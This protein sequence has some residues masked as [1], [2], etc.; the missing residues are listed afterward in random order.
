MR[1]YSTDNPGVWCGEGTPARDLVMVR[2]RGHAV[3]WTPWV[4]IPLH[5]VNAIASALFSGEV[6]SPY[7]TYYERK[8][9]Y[10][11]SGISKTLW[12]CA[13][14]LRIPC[15]QLVNDNAGVSHIAQFEI[16][17]IK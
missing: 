2:F 11:S 9:I 15:T 13:L 12:R 5:P 6:V 17:P 14:D 10:L 7:L 8:R 1:G 3:A 16:V 4:G